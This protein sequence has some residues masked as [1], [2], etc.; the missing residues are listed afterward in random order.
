MSDRNKDIS[1]EQEQDSGDRDGQK[2]AGGIVRGAGGP[3]FD[4][5][6]SAEEFGCA[7]PASRSWTGAVMRILMERVEELVSM[8]QKLKRLHEELSVE[9]GRPRTVGWLWKQK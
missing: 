2:K 5:L 6:R 3:D 7:E 9:N 1:D 4:I 8:K